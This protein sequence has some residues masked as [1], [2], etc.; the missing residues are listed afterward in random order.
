MNQERLD[1][2]TVILRKKYTGGLMERDKSVALYI[3]NLIDMLSTY[4]TEEF[5]KLSYDDDAEETLER[6]IEKATQRM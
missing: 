1:E 4:V 2:L 5:H 6:A 3:D